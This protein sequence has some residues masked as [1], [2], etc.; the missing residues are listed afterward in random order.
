MRV[1]RVIIILLERNYRKS[2]PELLGLWLI[3]H[4]PQSF[5][6][7]SIYKINIMIY[8]SWKGFVVF[9]FGGLDGGLVKLIGRNAGVQEFDV[10]S[11]VN[12]GWKGFF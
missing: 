5:S 4:A 3:S 10:L 11:L 2:Q 1:L 6:I 9:F 12:V 8:M 7:A